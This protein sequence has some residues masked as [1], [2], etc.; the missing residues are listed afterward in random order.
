[1]WDLRSP[2]GI[3]P[4]PPALEGKIVTTGL[5]GKSLLDFLFL[6]CRYIVFAL[7]ETTTKRFKDLLIVPETNLEVLVLNLI[8]IYTSFGFQ[9]KHC[10]HNILGNVINTEVLFFLN[11][12]IHI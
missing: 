1:M 4:A 8:I 11:G 6:T 5:P 12:N 9:M 10:Q 2:S 7:K 3:K